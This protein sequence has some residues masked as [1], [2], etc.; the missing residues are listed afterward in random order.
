MGPLPQI[1]GP[2]TSSLLPGCGDFH[3]LRLLFSSPCEG[4]DDFPF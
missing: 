4:L 2:T 1:P 3:S